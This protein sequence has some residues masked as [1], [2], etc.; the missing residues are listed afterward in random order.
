MKNDISNVMSF[1]EV[2]ANIIV[3]ILGCDMYY[4]FI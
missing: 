2:S 1:I 3:N 4:M